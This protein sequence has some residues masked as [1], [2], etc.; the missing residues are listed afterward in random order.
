MMTHEEVRE[1]V[2][3]ANVCGWQQPSWP[4]G[5]I[6]TRTRNTTGHTSPVGLQDD[7]TTPVAIERNGVWMEVAR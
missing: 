3:S 2:A 6:C 1:R 7:T 5:F 4:E